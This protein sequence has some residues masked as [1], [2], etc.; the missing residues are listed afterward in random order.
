MSEEKQ[1]TQNEKMVRGTFWSTAGNTLSRLL[2]ALYIIPWY[3]WMGEYGSQANALYGMGYNIYAY[4]LLLS[5]T[6]INVAVAKQIAKYN[7][8]GKE[9]HSIHLIRNFL[10]LMGIVGLVFAAV[11]YLASPLFATFSGSGR[12]LIPVIHSLSYAVLVFP[13]MSVVRGIFQGYND[14][15][16][17]AMSQIFEQLIRVIW[18]LLTAY[19]IMQ[20]GSGD[21]V[22]AVSQSTLAAF[23]GMLASMAVLIFYLHKAGLLKKIFAR[24][25]EK[26]SIDTFGLLKETFKEAIPFIITGSAIQTLQLID[27]GTFNN[28][29]AVFTNLSVKELNVLF[30][31]LSANPSKINMILISVATS[32]GGVGIP[33]LTESF[34][35]RNT[36]DMRKVVVNNLQ[37]LWIFILPAVVGSLI[38]A[39]P[40]YT[41]FYGLPEKDA[42]YL[43]IGVMAETLLLA[44]YSLMAPMLQALFENRKAIQYFLWGIL[45]KLVF[46][47]PTLYVFGAYG[48]IVSSSLALWIPSVLMYF[49]IQE[50]TGFDHADIRKGAKTILWMTA[51]MGL[52][53]GLGYWGLTFIYPVTGRLS[54]LVYV[55]VL[56]ALGVLVYGYLS[57]RTHQ[58]DS[59]IGSRAESL[60][61]KL[62]IK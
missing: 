57:L 2:G 41:V 8:M 19:L 37:M 43:F 36:E 38:L 10:K 1:L 35:K 25:T 15:K 3:A 23:I 45:A 50:V 16:P 18:M 17:Y 30:A 54:G 7:A 31:Y 34:V 48:P 47:I 12:E 20:M 32:I 40:I 4:F 52:V 21:Y 44:L 5:T 42:L 51:V 39:K 13:A 29:L 24:P 61:Q 53:V 9:D 11:M 49:R 14:F 6:G 59:I 58:V 27:Q 22:L 56:G 28:S 26:I 62:H 46:Q 33:V 55:I 60:R